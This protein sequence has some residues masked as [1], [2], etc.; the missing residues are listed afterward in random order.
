ML[1]SHKVKGANKNSSLNVQYRNPKITE[2]VWNPE[3][4]FLLPPIH[5]VWGVRSYMCWLELQEKG[6]LRAWAKC[7]SECQPII[8]NN[9]PIGVDKYCEYRFWLASS[10]R[11][12]KSKKSDYWSRKN[13]KFWHEIGFYE[14]AKMFMHLLTLS[15][16]PIKA[17]EPPAVIKSWPI[18]HLKLRNRQIWLALTPGLAFCPGSYS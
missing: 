8:P 16:Q 17:P 4:F 7:E 12:K 3:T 14:C 13:T 18:I 2:S 9:A 5:A 1:V 15:W 6:K 11:F 10:S